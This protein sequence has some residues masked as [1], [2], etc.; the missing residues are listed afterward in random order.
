[1]SLD[2]IN[3]FLSTACVKVITPNEAE[4]DAIKL[5]TKEVTGTTTK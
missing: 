3:K 1:V 4:F 2:I 5:L